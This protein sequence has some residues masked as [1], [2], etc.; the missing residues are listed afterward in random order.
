MSLYPPRAQI[1][2]Y[3]RPGLD[4]FFSDL[5]V[6]LNVSDWLHLHGQKQRKRDRQRWAGLW[7]APGEADA[8]SSIERPARLS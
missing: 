1:G 4:M 6:L 5:L 7:Y 3:L 8:F 2:T